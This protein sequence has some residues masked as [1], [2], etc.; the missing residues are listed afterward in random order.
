MAFKSYNTYSGVPELEVQHQRGHVC[1]DGMY[2][3]ARAQ[4][5]TVS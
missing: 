2:A 1:W 4:D 3:H 5:A